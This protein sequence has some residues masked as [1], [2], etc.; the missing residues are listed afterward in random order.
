MYFSVIWIV[1]LT[2]LGIGILESVQLPAAVE[3]ATWREVGFYTID[4]LLPIVELN[5]HHKQ[6]TS[7]LSAGV[8]TYFYFLK[9]MGWIIASFL[10]AGLSGLTKK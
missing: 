8:Q 4:M 5:A 2:A 7:Q 6:V 1:V 10:V 9:L 3:L